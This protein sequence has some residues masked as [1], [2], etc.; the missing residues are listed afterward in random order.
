MINSKTTNSNDKFE[1]VQNNKQKRNEN[2]KTFQK[3]Y[4][5]PNDPNTQCGYCKQVG[6]SIKD[7]P[8]NQN[9]TKNENSMWVAPWEKEK[10]KVLYRDYSSCRIY[11]SNCGEQGHREYSCK[12]PTFDKLLNTFQYLRNNQQNQFSFTNN[13]N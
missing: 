1:N 7:C 8:L 3:R 9:K 12:R 11:C 5:Q 2:Q 13:W 6:H 10:E 4:F